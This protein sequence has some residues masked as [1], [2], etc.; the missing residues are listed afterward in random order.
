MA[1]DGKVVIKRIKKSGG[2]GHHG[3]AW[4][5]AYADFVTAMMAFFLL[6]W[7]INTTTPEQ[8]RGIADYFAAQNISKST[9]G[10]GGVLAGTVF[11]QEGSRSGGTMSPVN[12]QTPPKP[13]DETLSKTSGPAKSGSTQA[14]G[15][16]TQNQEKSDDHIERQMPSEEHRL[17][18]QAQ[19]SLRQAMQQMPDIAELSRNILMTETPEGLDIQLVDEA[20]QAMFQPGTA[21]LYPKTRILLQ[22]VAKIVDRMPNRI[23]ITGHTDAAKFVGPNGLTNWELSAGRA[24]AAR[25]VLATEGLDSD[26]VF[27]VSG[28]A[29]SDPLLPD[30]PYASSNRRISILLMR[31][32]PV[33]PPGH[34]L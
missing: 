3:G 14:Q 27:E 22:Q 28:K 25:A 12:K 26:R 23:S 15:E 17:F 7:L 8:K 16:A 34:K 31:E 4:K 18:E 32:A 5:V 1:G 13:K 29:G 24:N 2:H 9:S 33:V 10:A 6:M 30:D 19:I 21:I 11:G 20:G